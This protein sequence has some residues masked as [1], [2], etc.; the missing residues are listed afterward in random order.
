[1]QDVIV[2]RV[3]N[4]IPARS[5]QNLRVPGQLAGRGQISIGARHSVRVQAVP[6]LYYEPTMGIAELA[7]ASP[8]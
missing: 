8:T 5:P 4:D 2:T 3:D 6:A 7:A 1:M